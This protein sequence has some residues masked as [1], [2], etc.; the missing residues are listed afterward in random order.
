MLIIFLAAILVGLIFAPLGCLCLWRRYIYFG[1]A[2]AHASLLAASISATCSI[3]VLYSGLLIASLFALIIH[4]LQ[5]SSGS[6]EIMSLVS[7]SMLSCGF[8]LAALFPTQLNITN[9]LVGDIL[10]VSRE[11]LLILV[12][13]LALV[14][15]FIVLFYRQIL[16]IAFNRDIAQIQGIKVKTI[17]LLFLL[18]LAIVVFLTIKMVG[19]LLVTTILL[20][21]AMAARMIAVNPVQMLFTSTIFAILASLLALVGSFYFDLPAMP[22]IVLVLFA[23]YLLLYM[24]K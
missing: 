20:I 10:A 6:N 1:D 2:L 14:I 13:L 11:D 23:I 9:L 7:S 12:I 18:T 22:S 16:L 4:R 21:P 17:E 3:P 5:N 8:I 24:L 15:G 19:A